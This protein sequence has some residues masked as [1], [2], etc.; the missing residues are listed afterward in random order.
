MNPKKVK[1]T[2]LKIKIRWALPEHRTCQ[3]QNSKPMAKSRAKPRARARQGKINRRP[4][5]PQCQSAKNINVHLRERMC[6]SLCICIVLRLRTPMRSK[7]PGAWGRP[8]KSGFP[9]LFAEAQ[10]PR[11]K[12][13]LGVLPFV[14]STVRPYTYVCAFEAQ[15]V[16]RR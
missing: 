5:G 2:V 15:S 16:L 7:L 8:G 9:G 14:G 6:I 12:S 1:K 11:F 13:S 4:K 3:G 10:G